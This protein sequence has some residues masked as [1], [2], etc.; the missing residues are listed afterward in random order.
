M[1]GREGLQGWACRTSKQDVEGFMTGPGGH[2]GWTFRASRQNLEGF[3]T[4]CELHYT[5]WRAS[6]R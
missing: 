5:T 6:R 2:Q 1:T 4:G 3:K